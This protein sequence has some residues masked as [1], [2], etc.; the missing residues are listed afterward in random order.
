MNQRQGSSTPSTQIVAS[1]AP[2]PNPPPWVGLA[3][4]FLEWFATRHG[5]AF[6]SKL[7]VPRGRA[8]LYISMDYLLVLIA[9]AVS[10]EATLLAFYTAVA[11]WAS[12]LAGVWKRT[13]RPSRS[14]FSRFLS[15]L[16]FGAVVYLRSLFFQ[17]VLDFGLK[18]AMLGGCLDRLGRRHIV[19]D[20]DGTR[21]AGRQRSLVG[22]ADYPP[23]RRR[24]DSVCAPGYL[25][26]KRG[27]VVRTRSVV[28]QAHT[29]EWLGTWGSA[30]N[31]DGYGDLIEACAAIGRY[32][33][34]HRLDRSQAVVRLDG[35]YG[36]IPP[37]G[38]VKKA[39]LGW[40]TRCC[41][42]AMLDKPVV[43]AVLA[44]GPL[45]TMEQPDTGTCRQ[46][47]DIP[48][49]QWEA[50]PHEPL[51]TRMIVA[52]TRMTPGR[53]RQVGKVKEG[54]RYELFV[55]DRDAA[56][57]PAADVLDLYF[58]RGAFEQTLSEDDQEQTA[59]RWCSHEPAG[60]EAWHIVHQWV[61]NLRIW[62][63]KPENAAIR[64]TE[65][66]AAYTPP[67]V[68][69]QP[70]LAPPQGPTA[71]DVPDPSPVE[72]PT[73][74]APGVMACNT[75]SDPPPPSSLSQRPPEEDV[76]LA[77]SP[78]EPP[79]PSQA[80]GVTAD[81]SASDPPPPSPQTPPAAPTPG[82]VAQACGRGS[83]RF[84][85]ADFH[86]IGIQLLCPAGHLLSYAYQQE[87]PKGI[88]LIYRARLEDC[89]PCPLR[90]K[91]IGG[92]S[93]LHYGRRVSVW[94]NEASGNIAAACPVLAPVPV[95]VPTPSPPA[96]Q[97][98]PTPGPQ[99]ILWEDIP[100]RSW[101]RSISGEFTLQRVDIEEVAP[102]IAS[103]TPR[104]RAARAHRR[105]TWNQ[106]AE[107]NA[108]H[109]P[110]RWVVHL[111]GV[112]PE[113]LKFLAS[114]RPLGEN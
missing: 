81:S 5:G 101:R 42:Y 59:D 54:W 10:G 34:H 80:P 25:G 70:T 71:E 82:T 6:R 49:V 15:A 26:R 95:P 73:M 39:G 63:G 62:L 4:L 40:V 100:A 44:A 67:T 48:V 36:H 51:A 30:G 43:R 114:N 3:V 104:T 29:K 76:V 37:I 28:Q 20:V 97:V 60:Q 56:G 83:G 61:W 46:L 68:A 102:P 38:T 64:Q 87:E 47:F 58:G 65:M 41:D 72:P 14:A 89:G 27:Q 96:L 74:Q 105:L 22:G 32:M 55:T 19:F 84:A 7:L 75:A 108:Y 18:G 17:D 53:K 8:G 50:G 106:R 93:R 2:Q 91:C 16:P 21:Q 98:V 12:T 99:P 109:G 11:P 23:A 45:Q 113:A 77:P 92:A 1:A 66:A 24:F 13:R 35:L 111:H 52:K 107:R 103:L 31:G 88:R 94:K 110:E 57:F 33:D 85:G 78:S 69:E 112:P 9:Y 90:E 86:W 79:P